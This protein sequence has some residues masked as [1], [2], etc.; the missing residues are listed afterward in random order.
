MDAVATAYVCLSCTRD[1]PLWVSL[2]VEEDSPGT[3]KRILNCD[4]RAGTRIG[5]T[6][7]A[8]SA[9]FPGLSARHQIEGRTA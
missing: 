5:P 9:Y 4:E 8:A 6:Q 2:G 3:V 7:H 1:Q